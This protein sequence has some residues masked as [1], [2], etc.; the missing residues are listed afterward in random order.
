[1]AR[2][3]VVD[4]AA[5][6]RMTIKQML[7]ANGHSMVG[8]AENGVEA[9]EKF[10]ELKPDVVLLDISMPQMNG[11]ETLKRLKILNPESKVIICSAIG[12]Q[13][14]LTEAIENGAENF[15]IKPFEASQLIEAIE[16]VVE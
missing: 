3:L 13:E 7:D 9:I 5:F 6:M 15:I 14:M 8:E 1:M 16:S 10:M 4:D 11:I 2:V 12:F